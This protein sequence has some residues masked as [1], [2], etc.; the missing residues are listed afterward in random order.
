MPAWITSLLRE[1]MPLPMPP[2]ASATITLCPRR[3]E[4][5]RNRQS[6]DARPDHQNVYY[7][8]L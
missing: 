8:L 7:G 2:V 3:A 4:R 5:P 1:E 6:D